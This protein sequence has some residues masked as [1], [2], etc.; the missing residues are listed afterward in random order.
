MKRRPTVNI[1]QI[2]KSAN[3]QIFEHYESAKILLLNRNG[4]NYRKPQQQLR[5]RKLDFKPDGR[6]DQTR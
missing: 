6:P 2:Y 3:A 1:R 5:N 4:G